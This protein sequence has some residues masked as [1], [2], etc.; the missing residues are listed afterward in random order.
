MCQSCEKD[1]LFVIPVVRQHYDKD[2]VET[3]VG[4]EYWCSNCIS[5]TSSEEYSIGAGV[6]DDKPPS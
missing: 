3:K 6:A 1:V 4:Q 2:G 5:T